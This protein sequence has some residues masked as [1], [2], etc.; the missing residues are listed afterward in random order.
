MTIATP[1][2]TRSRSPNPMLTFKR[3]GFILVNVLLVVSALFPFY[4]I[5]QPR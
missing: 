2:I 5:S 4:W 3:V 1:H